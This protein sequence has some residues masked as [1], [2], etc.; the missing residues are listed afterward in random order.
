MSLPTCYCTFPLQFDRKD[1]ETDLNAQLNEHL[2]KIESLT[3]EFALLQT[4]LTTCEDEKGSMA[5][6]TEDAKHAAESCEVKLQDLVEE[7]VCYIH[8]IIIPCH[9]YVFAAGRY[10]LYITGAL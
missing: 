6:V 9:I 1:L 2:G 3:Q 10:I 7:K 8:I 4:R 5:K